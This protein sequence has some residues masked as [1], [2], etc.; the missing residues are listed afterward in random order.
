MVTAGLVFHGT[1]YFFNLTLLVW[2][3]E[4]DIYL[5]AVKVY[6][7]QYLRGPIGEGASQ[8]EL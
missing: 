5:K 3:L 6:C 4:N 8:G 2:Y 7:I 1:K